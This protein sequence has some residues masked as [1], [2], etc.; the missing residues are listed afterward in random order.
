[1]REKDIRNDALQRWLA[2]FDRESPEEMVEEVLK[3]DSAIRKA[4]ERVVY[5]ANDKEALHEY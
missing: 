1:M 2:Y 3:M 5:V 4:Q